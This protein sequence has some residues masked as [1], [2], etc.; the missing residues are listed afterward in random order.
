MPTDEPGVDIT[1]SERRMPRHAL[2]KFNVVGKSHDCI[3]VKRQCQPLQCLL[4]IF[5]MHD[6]LGDHRIV[7]GRNGITLAHAGIDAH[8][9]VHGGRAQQVDRT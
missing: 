7:V 6:E 5:A 1:R 2:Q 4:A 3:F 8:V 9:G